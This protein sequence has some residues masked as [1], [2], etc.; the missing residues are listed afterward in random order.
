MIVIELT[1]ANSVKSNTPTNSNSHS[2]RNDFKMRMQSVMRVVGVH[3][4]ALAAT[5]I[6]T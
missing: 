3:A 5:C 6:A 1:Q 2:E 4:I